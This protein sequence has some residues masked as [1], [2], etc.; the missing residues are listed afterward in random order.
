[1]VKVKTQTGQIFSEPDV[2]KSETSRNVAE[3]YKY[4]RETDFYYVRKMEIN[5]DVPDEVVS[6]RVAARK[7]IRANGG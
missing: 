2:L 4:L 6:K 3:A 1:M 5:E 7:L